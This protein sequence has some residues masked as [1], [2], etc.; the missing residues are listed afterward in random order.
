VYQIHA[1][2]TASESVCLY[3]LLGKSSPVLDGQG[4]QNPLVILCIDQ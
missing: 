2:V 1:H 4:L 3:T